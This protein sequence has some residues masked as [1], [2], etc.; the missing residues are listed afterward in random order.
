MA[1]SLVL[2]G[3]FWASAIALVYWVGHDNKNIEKRDYRVIHFTLR[4]SLV[5]GIGAVILSVLVVLN[6]LKVIP[7]S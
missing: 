3:I 4:L 6:Q 1:Y 2:T 5:F 7:W